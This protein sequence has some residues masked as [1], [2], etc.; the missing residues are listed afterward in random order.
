MNASEI[1]RRKR[2][3]ISGPMTGLPDFNA[4]AFNAAAADLRRCGFGV[5]SP[6]EMDL[7]IG[8]DPSVGSPEDFDLPA[9]VRR[10]ID[11]LIDCDAIVM[12]PGHEASKGATAERYVADWL[13]KEIL[14][15]PTLATYGPP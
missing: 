13:G 8:F 9:A 12:L 2:F 11:A 14:V 3:Y 5:V 7:E 4:P 10:D 6:I 15:Y 1:L